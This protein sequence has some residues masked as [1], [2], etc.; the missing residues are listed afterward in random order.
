M[1]HHNLDWD[2]IGRFRIAIYFMGRSSLKFHTPNQ[3]DRQSLSTLLTNNVIDEPCI[4]YVDLISET[5]NRHMANIVP[6]GERDVLDGVEECVLMRWD[7]G[8]K[9]LVR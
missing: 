6:D 3:T 4:T 7:S 9:G 5:W 8:G 2:L 1:S